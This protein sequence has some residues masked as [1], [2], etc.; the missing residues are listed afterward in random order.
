MS[1][2][3]GLSLQPDAAR[4]TLPAFLDDVAARHGQ[5]VALVFENR[6]LTFVALRGRVRSLARALIAKGVGRGTHVALLVSNR[7]EWVVSAFAVA[8]AGGVVVPVSTF[9]TAEERTHVLRHADA[10]LL[11]LQPSLLKHRYLDDLIACEPEKAL[12]SLRQVIVLDGAEGGVPALRTALTIESWDEAV[13]AAERVPEPDLDLRAR[14]VT[15]EDDAMIVYTSGSTAEPKGVLHTQRAAVIQSWRFAEFLGLAPHDTV[16]TAYP[17]FWT[18]GFAMS[19]GASLAAGATLLLEETFEAE[20]ALATIERHH[21]TAIHAWPHQEKALAE[22]PAAASRDLRSIAQ[23]NLSSPLAPLA[24]ITE[25]RWGR[26][27]TYGLTETFTLVTAIPATAPAAERRANH[28]RVLP[29]CE[30]RIVDPESGALLDA[31]QEGEIAVRGLTL[32]RGYHKVPRESTFD[33]EGFFHTGDS[34]RIDAMGKLHWHGRMTGMIKT[35]GANV[36]PVEIENQLRSFPGLRAA[37]AVGVR[38]A[39]LG[40]IVVL[41]AVAEPGANADNGSVT[42]A[43]VRAYLRARLAAYKVPKRVL[44]F[45]HDEVA[46]TGTQKIQ[47]APLREAALARLKAEHCV[48]E[49]VAYS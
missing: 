16:W 18:A 37:V 17:L 49:G 2:E 40:E 39:S 34:G 12:P 33:A 35:G 19:L 25:D 24:G 8:L 32:M 44:F 30:L 11:I 43:D 4:Y 6:S 41:C 31:N 28:G 3:A 7:P 10:E 29:G 36:S 20:Q 9:A 13:R 23:V 47:A 14:A 15:P 42:E 27:A 21:A 5:R 1:V 48:I 46:F 45:A 26:S 22:H 38:H